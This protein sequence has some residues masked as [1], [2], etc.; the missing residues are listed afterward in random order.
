MGRTAKIPR[1]EALRSAMKLFWSR[2]F[3]ATTMEDVEKSTRLQRGSVYAYF[4]SKEDLFRESLDLYQ[5]EIVLDRRQRV[6]NAK[7]AKAGILLFFSILIEHSVLERERPGCLNTNTAVELSVIDK[8]LAKR[9]R[10]GLGSWEDFWIELID[11]AKVEGS[12]AANADSKALALL[13]IVLTQGLNVVSKVNP[14]RADLNKVVQTALN[15][16][17]QK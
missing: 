16:F 5:R 1:D 10:S 7:S 6:Q 12:I 14:N 8:E 11:R 3:H 4:K 2:G 17:I 13:L 9:S 15:F